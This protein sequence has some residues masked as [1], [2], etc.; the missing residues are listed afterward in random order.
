MKFNLK[1]ATY[2]QPVNLIRR[3]KNA[4]FR[5]FTVLRTYYFLWMGQLLVNMDTR[6]CNIQLGKKKE[7]MKALLRGFQSARTCWLF[8]AGSLHENTINYNMKCSIWSLSILYKK[9][10]QFSKIVI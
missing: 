6:I 4:L 10:L 5:S 8:S 3:E 1:N 7:I 2:T 9:Y